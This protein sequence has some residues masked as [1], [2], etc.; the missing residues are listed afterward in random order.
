LP[1]SFHAPT[2]KACQQ[3]L[4]IVGSLESTK[5]I[6]SRGFREK[7]FKKATATTTSRL[8]NRER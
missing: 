1:Y 6:R 7:E 5:V 8:L 4:V 3:K 2:N